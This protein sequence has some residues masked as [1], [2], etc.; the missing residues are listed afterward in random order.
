MGAERVIDDVVPP[1]VVR[2]S[3]GMAWARLGLTLVMLVAALVFGRAVPPGGWLLI[4]IFLVV[5]LV[6]S[7]WTFIDLGPRLILRQDGL[8][9]RDWPSRQLSFTAW[10]RFSEARIIE[11][12]RRL[13]LFWLRLELI[14]GTDRGCVQ[15]KLEGLDVDED[16]LKRAIHLRA[17]HLFPDLEAAA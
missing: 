1:L 14:D 6:S 8:L 15:V 3:R 17:Q 4:A 10:T 16:D 9:W 12:R 5:C 7:L 2:A 13:D 11:H